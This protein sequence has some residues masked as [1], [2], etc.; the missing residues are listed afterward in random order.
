MKAVLLKV[1]LALLFPI[2]LTA[3]LYYGRQFLIPLC[4]AILLAMLMA[5]LCRYL[6]KKGCSRAVSCAVCIAVLVLA[7]SLL[8]AVVIF[9]LYD[10]L[11]D[12]DKISAKM[13]EM[14]SNIQDYINQRSGISANRQQEVM[15]EQVDKLKQS[16]GGQFSKVAGSITGAIGGLVISLVFTYLMLFHK[17]KYEKFFI[18]L[19]KD[20]DEKEVRE[21]LGQITHVSQQYLT[22]RILSMM[23]LFIL[24]AVALLVIG[25]KNALLLSAIASA[26]TIVPYVGP[27]L[28]GLFPIMTAFVTEDSMQPAIWVGV[29]LVV[30]QVLD[31]YFVEPLV[32]GGEV[33]LTALSTIAAILAGGFIW[34]IAGMVLFIPML[35]IAKIIF[36]HTEGLKPFGYLVGDEGK[37]PSEKIK[38]WFQNR[39]K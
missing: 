34:G 22:G 9:Q 15:N 33:R 2:L 14:W 19:N 17:E 37:S 12:M 4:L 26:L 5:P 36:D 1:N 10:F 20:R 30:I 18:G 28:G 13:H 32:I 16:S 7:F 21:V 39:K 3:V 38:S 35:S 24:Y 23:F 31:N 11:K 6:D 29:A 27:I 25:I 8:F